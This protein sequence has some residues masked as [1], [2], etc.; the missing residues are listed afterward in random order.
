[1]KTKY[2]R[3]MAVL[4]TA[5][6]LNINMI[7]Y[8]APSKNWA[9]DDYRKANIY[10]TYGQQVE[11]PFSKF[12]AIRYSGGEPVDIVESYSGYD[13]NTEFPTLVCYV[14]DTLKFEDHSDSTQGNIVEWDWQRFGAMGDS[15]R[16]Y[17]Y[18]IVNEDNYYCA[19]P[20]ETIFYLCV[21]SDLKV[22][23]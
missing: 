9:A 20:G 2:M 12:A 19:E 1:M 14:G 4:M 15:Y 22:K 23:N 18:N 13:L 8:A 3:V 17:K 7:A 6:F 10:N 21:K 11:K 16:T 5:I